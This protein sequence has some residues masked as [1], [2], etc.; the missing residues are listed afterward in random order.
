VVAWRECWKVAFAGRL[1]ASPAWRGRPPSRHACWRRAVRKRRTPTWWCSGTA[2]GCTVY[3][4]YDSKPPAGSS[5]TN[6]FGITLSVG[7]TF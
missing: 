3:D 1:H 5:S 7:W 2:T 6:V 4:S